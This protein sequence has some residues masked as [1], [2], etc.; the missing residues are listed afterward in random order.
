MLKTK[1]PWVIFLLGLSACGPVAQMSSDESVS[2]STFR[3]ERLNYQERMSLLPNPLFEAVFNEDVLSVIKQIDQN[4]QWIE[5]RNEE[6][7]ESPLGLALRLGFGREAALILPHISNEGLFELNKDNESLAFLASRSGLPSSI[8]SIADRV[9]MNLGSFEDFS[10]R[11]LDQR[12]KSG[13]RAL[14]VAKDRRVLIAL[15]EQYYRGTV[16]IPGWAFTQSRDLNENTFLHAAARDNRS[17]IGLWAAQTFCSDPGS[18]SWLD[19]VKR[20]G[21][22]AV[23]LFHFAVRDLG[24]PTDLIVNRVNNLGQT[25]LHSA[26]EFGSFEFI[27]Q[28]TQCQWLNPLM[29]DQ[30]GD[31]AAHVFLKKLDFRRE[32]QPQVIRDSFQQLSRSLST[33]QA[34]YRNPHRLLQ[35]QNQK[36]QTLAHLAAQLADPTFYKFL[37]SQFFIESTD[38]SGLT[39]DQ[40]RKAR[41]TQLLNPAIR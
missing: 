28:L 18:N 11:K 37:Q 21:I 23:R 35:V 17:D 16:E 33:V 29:Q 14:F 40:M 27:Q 3:H 36:G 24:S 10:F 30:N 13:Q 15:R 25:A 38:Q 9:Y 8:R 41:D 12:D 7:G 19:R 1:V 22:N 39:P 5:A 31:T 2:A 6:M 26:A 34:F 4:P 20:W 32:Q